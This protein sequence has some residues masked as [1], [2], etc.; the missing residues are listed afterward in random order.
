MEPINIFND[1]VIVPENDNCSICLSIMDNNLIIH[2][3]KECKH[4]F[5]SSCLIEWLRTSNSCPMCRHVNDVIYNPAIS[6]KYIINFLRSKK[7]TNK[8]LKEIYKKYQKYNIK[9]KEEKKSSSEFEKQ[10]KD[11]IKNY[12][13]R[14]AKRRKAFWNLQRIKRNIKDLP[15]TPILIK[16]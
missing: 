13:I 2:E 7:N 14:R 5:H 16:K 1:N 6:F 15:F 3:I 12:N 9:Y 11:F 8:N 4:K 10:N